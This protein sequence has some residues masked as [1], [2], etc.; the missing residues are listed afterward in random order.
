MIDRIG[1]ISALQGF[2]QSRLP[3]FT[4]EEQDYIKGTYD[5]LAI[6]T[7]TSQYAAASEDLPPGTV[8]YWKDLNVKTFVDDDWDQ[9]ASN[10]LRVVPWGIRKLLKWMSDTY[11]NPEIFVSEN[12]YS[13]TGGLE[14]QE[15]IDYLRNYLS[16]VLES[17]LDDGVNVTRYTCWSLMDNF[18]WNSGYSVKFGLY[19]VDFN[20]PD[21]PRI[22]KASVGYFKQVLNTKCLVDSCE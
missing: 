7:Y 21:R 1:N 15:R 5:F 9:A 12:G 8:D 6:N 16:S 19:S 3:V 22:P 2:N 13:D 20:D 10:W 14:D 4:E 11:D 18:E 17:I